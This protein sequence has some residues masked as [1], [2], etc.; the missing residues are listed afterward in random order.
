MEKGGNNFHHFALSLLSCGVKIIQ[1]CH[2]LNIHAYGKAKQK[3]WKNIETTLQN[4]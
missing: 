2:E 4:M 1:F 3:K